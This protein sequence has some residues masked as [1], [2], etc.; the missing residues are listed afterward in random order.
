MTTISGFNEFV[1]ELERLRETK[2]NPDEWYFV[3]GQ[4]VGEHSINAADV[5]DDYAEHM[6]E[7]P[8]EEQD[9]NEN[10]DGFYQ[11][12]TQGWSA[13]AFADDVEFV[14]E[15]GFSRTHDTIDRR[16]NGLLLVHESVLSEEA[17]QIAEGKAEP[18]APADD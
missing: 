13:D 18:E 8:P 12:G 14:S 1:E 5:P 9:A 17:L 2:E 11:I 15:V 16:V 3:S 4:Q 10:V 6:E 7:L